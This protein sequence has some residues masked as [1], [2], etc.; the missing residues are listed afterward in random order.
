MDMCAC[1]CVKADGVTDATVFMHWSK[2]LQHNFGLLMAHSGL[3][4][5]QGISY[6]V[7][8]WCTLS[9]EERR[10]QAI[11]IIILVCVIFSNHCNYV[12]EILTYAVKNFK[13]FNLNIYKIV[14]LRED[15][16]QRE[17][18]GLHGDEFTTG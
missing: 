17:C 1:V 15:G 11:K 14:R 16:L 5:C 12:A 6:H 10:V 3:F 7:F 4:F 8:Q 18:K 9:V 13:C 2:L